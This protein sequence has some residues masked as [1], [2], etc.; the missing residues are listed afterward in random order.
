MKISILTVFPSLYGPFLSTSLVDRAQ[1]RG[2][3][4][5]DVQGLFSFVEPK[6]RIDAPVYGH[7]S[8]ML[9]KPL[10]IQKAVEHQEQKWG[11]SFKIFFSPHGQKLTQ[12]LLEQIAQDVQQKQHIMLLPA[13]YE[14]MD[15]RV[16]EQYADR[17]ISVGDFVLMGGDIPAMMFL[18]GFLR[19]IPGVVG[20]EVSI[21]EESFAGPFIDYPS[22]TEPVEWLGRRVPDVVRSGDHGAIE[23]WRKKEAVQRTVYGHFGWL[24]SQPLRSAEKKAVAAE[25]PP[26]YAV[27][28]HTD[29]LIGNERTVGTTSVTT[30]DIHDIARSSHTFSIRHYFMVTPLEDQQKIVKSVLHFWHDGPGVPYNSNRSQAVKNVSVA[31]SLDAVC[32]EIEKKEGQKPILVGTSAVATLH[33]HGISYDDQAEVWGHKRPVLLVFGTGRGLAPALLE[34]MDY[35]LQPITGLSDFNHLSVR[36]AAAI[37][38]DRWLGLKAVEAE[39]E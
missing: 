35:L 10:V 16:E 1:Q 6:E 38:F 39:D 34:R 32:E 26:H 12:R 31:D 30:L 11:D 22:Y 28:M 33:P 17:I 4:T 3:V 15:A 20:K 29:V 19:L 23:A 36:S 27:L 14:G 5:C 25:I 9:I 2:L 37:I 8:G 13:R 18:E 21:K 7:G 24:R